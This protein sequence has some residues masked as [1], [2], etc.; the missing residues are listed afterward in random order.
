[1]G[2]KGRLFT[3]YTLVDLDFES[4]NCITHLKKTKT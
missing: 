4:C 1:M 2:K 3:L